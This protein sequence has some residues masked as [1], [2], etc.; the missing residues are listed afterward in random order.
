MLEMDNILD[1]L[2]IIDIKV[3]KNIND[4]DRDE[5]NNII[6]PKIF[7]IFYDKG[8]KLKVT[9]Y[10]QIRDEQYLNPYNKKN[11]EIAE[12]NGNLVVEIDKLKE[13]NYHGNNQ[14]IEIS[15]V[16]VNGT[17]FKFDYKYI[18]KYKLFNDIEIDNSETIEVEEDTIS[19]I[20]K[21]DETEYKNM[22]DANQTYI[23]GKDEAIFR[24]NAD[25]PVEE[26]TNND[27]TTT[28]KTITRTSN[29]PKTG[30]DIMLWASI[31]VVAMLG[32][33]CTS[34]AQQKKK[35]NIN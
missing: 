1:N 19:K 27:E 16:D 2:D 31:M 4:E 35:K 6:L 3:T 15:V 26:T 13:L 12:I 32:I 30:D 34:F 18:I 20:D 29:N 11:I 33:V 21:S 7:K 10:D 28:A 17:Y 9:I 22:D 24:I 5:F 14:F 25:I 23:I 8:F